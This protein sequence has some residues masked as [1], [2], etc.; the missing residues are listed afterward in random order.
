VAVCAED[1][2]WRRPGPDDTARTVW[3]DNRY[4]DVVTGGVPERVL[5]DCSA[6]G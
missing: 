6:A 4:V 5:V 1:R 2:D 3:R